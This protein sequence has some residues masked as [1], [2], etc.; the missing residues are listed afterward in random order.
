MLLLG[1]SSMDPKRN[2][3]WKACV[4]SGAFLMEKQRLQLDNHY[5]DALL[6]C[7]PELHHILLVSLCEKVG[8]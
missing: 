3:E 2:S 4:F 5:P 8:D 6:S 1:V 7:V